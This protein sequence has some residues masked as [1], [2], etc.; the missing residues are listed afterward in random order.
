MK[1]SFIIILAAS[2]L[3][4]VSCESLREEFQPVFTIEYEDPAAEEPASMTATHTIAELAAKYETGNPWEVNENII[5]SGI[6]S[7]TDKYGNFYKSFYI[8]DETGGMEIKLGKNG[9]YNDYLPG[10][11]IWVKCTGLTLGMYGYKSGSGNGMVQIGFSDPS[12]SYETSYMESQ[13]L[14]D[15]HVFKG[16]VEG[17]VEPIVLSEDELPSRSATQASDSN[18]GKLVT[19]KN[20]YYGCLDSY[21]SWNE[22]FALLYLDSNKDKDSSSN[23]IFVSGQDTGITT[24]AMSETKMKSYLLSGV[25]DDISIGN[26]NDYNYGTVGDYKEDGTYPDIEK[27]AASVSQYFRTRASKTD[28]GTCIQIRTSGYSR[29][30]DTEIPAEVLSGEKTINVT[31][32]LNLYQGNIQ[33]IINN[34]DDIEVND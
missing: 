15:S 14:I 26:A 28:C 27:A 33:I 7:T 5:I 34:I 2:A 20:L 13:L 24:W 8:Q 31:G 9:L 10:Q 6:I 12:G 25:W 23:R 30:A 21:G 16:T 4:L 19:I 3:A 32:I 22:A 1:K 29:F 18:I 11:R 17:E